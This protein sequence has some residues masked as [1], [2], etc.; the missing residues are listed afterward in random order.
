MTPPKFKLGDKVVADAKRGKVFIFVIDNILLT[1][2]GVFYPY[3][4][5]DEPQTLYHF[6]EKD[7]KLYTEPKPKVKK[8][9]Y[10]VKNYSCAYEE[11]SRYP[12]TEEVA[13]ELYKTPHIQ[14]VQRLDWSMVEVPDD[15]KD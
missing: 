6:E 13:N 15:S 8:W 12:Y 9:F 10:L 7:L 14:W 5:K 4:D 2:A 11:M 1:K 3:S